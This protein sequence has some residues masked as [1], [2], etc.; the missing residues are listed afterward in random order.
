MKPLPIAVFVLC[1]C[2]AGAQVSIT[3]SDMVGAGD[4]V[5]VSYAASTGTADYT[6]FGPNYLWDFS[7]LAPYAQQVMRYDQPSAFPFTSMATVAHVNLSP[8]SIPGLGI[9]PS[10]FT[11][12]YKGS[13]SSF[14]Q[15]GSSF[16]YPQV[17]NFP[18]PVIYSSS[19]HIYNFPLDYPDHDTS[20]AA[21]SFNA[22]SFGLF[23]IGETIHRE[24]AVDGWGTLI[25]PFGTFQ[26]LRQVSYVTKV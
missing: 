2:S 18:I 10:D 21:W 13:S 26:C 11:D 23:Y 15:V 14:R 3:N 5:R 12:Y 19:D 20:D 4:S 25:T 7:Q 6:V 17:I 16:L 22:Q 8:D 24:S 1:V 9:I